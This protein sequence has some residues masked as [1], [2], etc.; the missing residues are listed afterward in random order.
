MST[1]ESD[2]LYK[3]FNLAAVP[4]VFVYDQQGN[5]RK[6][7]DNEQAKSK[8]EQYTYDDVKALVAELVAAPPAA[9]TS[10]EAETSEAPPAPEAPGDDGADK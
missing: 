3:K 8:E 7:F 6:R 4:A 10:S 9:A 2:A 1:E 5:L